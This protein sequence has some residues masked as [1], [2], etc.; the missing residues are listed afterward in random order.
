MGRDVCNRKELCEERYTEI[1]KKKLSWRA[2]RNVVYAPI[3]ESGQ[4]R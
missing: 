2:E 3:D 4:C 1:I